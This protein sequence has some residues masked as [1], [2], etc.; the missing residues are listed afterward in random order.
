M[1]RNLKISLERDFV[2]KIERKCEMI[3]T[4]L[5][6]VSALHEES[7]YRSC[8]EQVPDF[9]KE[10][11]DRLKL[12]EDKALSVGAWILYE[13]MKKEYSL[14]G[15]EMFNIS[16]SGDYVLCTI[17][18][19]EGAQV[20]CDLEKIASRERFEAIAKRYF[21]PEECEQIYSV[22]DFYRF[23]VLKESFQKATRLG[24]KLAINTFS[25]AFTSE[26]SPFL[27]KQPY[28]KGYYFKEYKVEN[29]LYKI[30]VCS[31]VDAFAP[32]IKLVKV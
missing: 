8:Y 27:Q 24:S 16:H 32:E 11:A 10:K 15:N 13:M 2:L 7:K 6:D 21:C 31:D 17:A 9:R 14:Q 12:Q 3:V 28:E 18:I 19:G 26:G 22:E 23:W 4:W 5:A 30:A 29:L 25:F 20:G 1:L